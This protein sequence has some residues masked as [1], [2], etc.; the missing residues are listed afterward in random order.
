MRHLNVRNRSLTQI[1]RRWKAF[2]IACTSTIGN[3]DTFWFSADHGIYVKTSLR[4]T[5]KSGFG[6]GTQEAELVSQAIR[7]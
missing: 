6:P 5:E 3:E 7:K 2:K 1:P 4:R